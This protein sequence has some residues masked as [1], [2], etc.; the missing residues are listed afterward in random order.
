MKVTLR[1]ILMSFL[2]KMRCKWYF[3]DEPREKILEKSAFNIK[4]NWNPRNGHP[5]FEI[6]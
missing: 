4:S 3:R 2:K 6:L 5:A 1:G